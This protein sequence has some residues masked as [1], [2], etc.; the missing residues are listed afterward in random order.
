ME[1]QWWASIMTCW[2]ASKPATLRK[3]CILP[4]DRFRAWYTCPSCA[5]RAALG[6]GSKAPKGGGHRLYK[7][8][9]RFRSRGTAPLG[10]I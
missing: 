4:T 6:I 8:R 2:N 10:K 5:F 3:R 1:C 7:L 9:T